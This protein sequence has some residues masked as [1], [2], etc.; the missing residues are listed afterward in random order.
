MRGVWLEEAG[1]N[2]GQSLKVKV[3]RKRIVIWVA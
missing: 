2:V 3:Q 1:F